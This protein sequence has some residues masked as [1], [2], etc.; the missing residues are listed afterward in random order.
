MT[1]LTLTAVDIVRRSIVLVLFD[2]PGD[3]PGVEGGEHGLVDPHHVTLGGQRDPLGATHH[4]ALVLV[5]VQLPGQGL[6]VGQGLPDLRPLGP[7]I[8]P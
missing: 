4:R 1:R 3:H 6:D 2:D 7:R 5:V 8:S